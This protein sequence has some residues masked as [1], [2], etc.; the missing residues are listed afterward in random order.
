MHPTSYLVW[1]LIHY[2]TTYVHTLVSTLFRVIQSSPPDPNELESLAFNWSSLD[3][4]PEYL[5]N[6]LVGISPPTHFFGHKTLHWGGNPRQLK[7]AP[8]FWIYLSARLKWVS[9][10]AAR[11]AQALA[12]WWRCCLK[13]TWANHRER[14]PLFPTTHWLILTAAYSFE[15]LWL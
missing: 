5:T 2:E 9:S 13:K 15:L 3:F 10:V 12:E 7:S 8:G 14:G 11:W 1:C 6:S 4:G